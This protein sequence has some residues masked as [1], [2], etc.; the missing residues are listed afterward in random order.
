MQKVKTKEETGH[1][2][3]KCRKEMESSSTESEVEIKQSNRRNSFHDSAGCLR[4]AMKSE[5]LGEGEI[6][7]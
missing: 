5:K 7:T 1:Q 4:L 3:Q 2:R 6:S